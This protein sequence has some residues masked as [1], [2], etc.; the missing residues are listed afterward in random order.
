MHDIFLL[1]KISKSLNEICEKNNIKKITQLAIVVNYH[2]HVN[3]KNLMEHLQ[4][5][6][7]DIV[8]ENLEITVQKED[9]EDQVAIICS[10]QGESLD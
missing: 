2:S 1:N 10:I 4:E 8:S 5:N 3:E 7:K 9:I 6:N